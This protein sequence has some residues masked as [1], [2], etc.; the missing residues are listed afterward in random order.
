MDESEIPLSSTGAWILS[1]IIDA[2]YQLYWFIWI[3]VSGEGVEWKY[4]SFDIDSDDTEYSLSLKH[5]NTKT[6][7]LA[8]NHSLLPTRPCGDCERPIYAHSLDYLCPVCRA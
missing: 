5:L 4:S 1:H 2:P 3:N 6:Y 7:Q 8:P